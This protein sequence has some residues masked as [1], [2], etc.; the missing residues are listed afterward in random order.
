MCGRDRIETMAAMCL[1]I[2]SSRIAG[3]SPLIVGANRDER[4]DRRGIAL[5]VLSTANPRILGGLDELA[6]GTWLCVNEHGVLAGVTNR[7]MPAGRD[8]AKRS[9]GEVALA[10]ARH[11][12]ARRGLDALVHD[13]RPGEFNPFWMLVGDRESLYF[14]DSTACDE[15]TVTELG[16][17]IHVLENSPIDVV[18]PKSRYVTDRFGHHA[19]TDDQSTQAAMMDVLRDHTIPPRASDRPT[20]GS[21]A[22]PGLFACCVHSDG[23]GTRSAA[24]VTVP[25]SRAAPIS[26]RACNGPSCVNEYLDYGALWSQAAPS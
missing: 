6:G 3:C 2:A 8:P 19:P 7:P 23:Y 1:L 15:F 13:R 14:L 10:I 20:D 25:K 12:S 17:G 22:R 16:P 18:T 26:V 5:T 24:L 21:V 11:D 9:R 4:Y